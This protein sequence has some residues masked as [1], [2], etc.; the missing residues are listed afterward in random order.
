MN[1]NIILIIGPT[2]SGK[3]YLQNQFAKQGYYKVISATT[4]KPRTGESDGV[5][6]YFKSENNFHKLEFIEKEKFGEH[7]YGTPK[8][9]FNKDL[10]VHVVEPKGA[11]NL[12]KMFP[13]AKI[14]FINI[15]KDQIQLNDDGLD[16]KRNHRGEILL[17]DFPIDTPPDLVVQRREDVSFEFVKKNLKL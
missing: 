10:I 9:E 8:S 17:S 2:R 4:R 5:D 16:N 3:T 14:I 11:L 7:W 15:S 13:L 6:Y 12:K 1:K